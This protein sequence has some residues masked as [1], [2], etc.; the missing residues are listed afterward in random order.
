MGNILLLTDFSVGANNAAAYALKL[1]WQLG[2]DLI[3][4]HVKDV[5]SDGAIANDT[6]RKFDDLKNSI[7]AM[8]PGK[9]YLQP[10]L[11]DI[12]VKGQ[13]K[14]GIAKVLKEKEIDLVVIGATDGENKTGFLFGKRVREII[15]WVSHPILLVPPAA[16]FKKIENVFYV[17]DIR[18]AS[19]QVIA[20]LMRLVQLLRA[21]F[22][23]LHVGVSGRPELPADHAQSLFN[24]FMAN[25]PGQAPRFLIRNEGSNPEMIIRELF[26]KHGQD[27]LAVA[28]REHHF[29]GH[30]FM[31]H[32]TEEA[33]I[34][35][36]IPMLVMPT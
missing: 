15:D 33:V 25:I 10:V 4:L 14:E 31:E 21:N 18:Y 13:L 28:H 29:F 8:N 27:V 23:V 1:A 36:E 26:V 24:D 35:K 34:Y 9:D 2:F 6:L 20:R 11:M 16:S 3:L 12:I 5:G 30:I 7:S 19:P 22:S 17:T 32:P